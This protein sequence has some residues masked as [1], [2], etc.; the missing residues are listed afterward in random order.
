MNNSS[1]LNL[2]AERIESLK[3]GILSAFA[4]L[5]A[6]GTITVI[7][8]L[9]LAQQFDTLAGL[10]IAT[11][12]INLL[13]SGAVAWLSG[14]LFGITY[15]YIIRQDN[16]SH[17][18]EGAVLAFGLVRGLAQLD[19]GL[20]LQDSFWPFIVLALESVL[21][22]AIARFTLDLAIQSRWVK[23]FK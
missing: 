18:Q 8:Q 14:F 17:L 9:I 7:N 6:F 5:L 2:A 23:P 15:R 21:L 16:N 11:V 1:E 22:F 20:K 3:A 19:V 12:D 10:Q 4:L 13:I